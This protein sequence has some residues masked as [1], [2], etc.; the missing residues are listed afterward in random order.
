MRASA[1]PALRRWCYGLVVGAVPLSDAFEALLRPIATSRRTVWL[2]LNAPILLY[3]WVTYFKFRSNLST[4]FPS[5]HP[6]T[7]ALA[8]HPDLQVR[9]VAK[10]VVSP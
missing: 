8:E 3:V 1:L 4:P 10:L 6:L 2:A 7:L 9:S 5:S